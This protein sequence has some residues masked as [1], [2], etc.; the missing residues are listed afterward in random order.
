MDVM[1]V[2]RTGRKDA[3]VESCRGSVI[4]KT[5]MCEEEKG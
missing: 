3:T 2:V 1:V 5:A 4:H